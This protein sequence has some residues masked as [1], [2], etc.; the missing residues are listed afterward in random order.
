MDELSHDDEKQVAHKKL[1]SL[2]LEGIESESSEMTKQDWIDIRSEGL[3][4]L[5]ARL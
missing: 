1:E 3:K 4:L 5:E 2:L